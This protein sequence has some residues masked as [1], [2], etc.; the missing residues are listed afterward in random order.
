[1]LERDPV[2]YTWVKGMRSPSIYGGYF[3]DVTRRCNLRCD[4]CFYPLVK[5]DP[6][7]LFS[8]GNIVD[9]CAAN[10]HMA[11]FILTGGEPTIRPDIIELIR[12]VSKVGPVELLTNGVKL[13]DEEF[14]EK[15]MPLITHRNQRGELVANLNLSIH[16]DQTDK[17]RDVV[18]LCRK[19]SIRIESALIV[20]DSEERFGEAMKIAKEIS[21]VVVAYRIK[22]A[23]V[24]WNE[25]KPGKSSDGK[26]IFVSDMVSW[27]EKLGGKGSWVL[28]P[29][30]HNKSVILNVL[31]G[32][33]AMMLVSW[34]DVNNI[35]LNDVNCAPYYRA[36]NGAILNFVT[37]S[38]VNEG[39][40]KGYLDGRKM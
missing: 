34:H 6:E 39:I 38:L 28:L 3:V 35:D 2:F 20:I 4:Y 1:M 22:A 10:R 23:S 27:L 32:G 18:A 19:H 31:W 21:D 36:R 40:A 25:Q 13:A 5:Q 30:R 33:M 29:D 16:D 8:I 11:P 12:E 7:G 17:W 15:V 24:L 26:K 9:E 37:A 14:F